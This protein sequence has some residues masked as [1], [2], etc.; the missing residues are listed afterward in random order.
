MKTHPCLVLVFL[1]RIGD[2]SIPAWR[3]TL[4]WFVFL[5][6]GLGILP[7]LH[8]DPPLAGSFYFKAFG[9]VCHSCMKTHLVSLEKK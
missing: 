4:A 3:P 7:F 1:Q 8:G 2:T 6:K 5:A 9:I